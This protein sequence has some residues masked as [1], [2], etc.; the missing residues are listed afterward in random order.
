[1][2]SLGTIALI[3][4]LLLGSLGAHAHSIVDRASPSPGSTVRTPPREVSIRFTQ[5]LEPAF[6][7]MTVTNA[8]GE[9][10][11]TGAASAD[12]NTMRVSLQQIDSGTYRV[13]WRVLSVDTHTTQGAFNFHVR[14]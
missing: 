2:R 10:V 4:S 7:T 12:G 14:P 8:A 13:T 1:M 3:P 6:S 9:R 5:K 11:D